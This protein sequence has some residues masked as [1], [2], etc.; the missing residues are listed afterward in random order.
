MS[1]QTETHNPLCFYITLLFLELT[2]HIWM[3]HC[4]IATLDTVDMLCRLTQLKDNKWM[5]LCFCIT[6]MNKVEVV[7]L[8]N[9]FVEVSSAARHFASW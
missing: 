5:L 1:T 8:R 4:K 9:N 3:K 7:F 2:Q 6:K